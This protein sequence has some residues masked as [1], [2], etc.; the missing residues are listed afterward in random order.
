MAS[1][2]QSVTVSYMAYNT[3]TGAYV[4]GDLANHTIK[5]I[6]DGTETSPT[7]APY[8]ADNNNMPGMYALTLTAAE[9][10]HNVVIIGGKS[11]S[12][13]VIIIP[14]IISFEQLPQAL[15][16]NSFVKASLQDVFNDSTCASNLQRATASIATGS[17]GSGSTTTNIVAGSLFPAMQVVGQYIGRIVIFDKGTTTTALRGQATTIT[18]NDANGNIQVTTLTNAPVLGDTFTIT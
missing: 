17:V 13:N 2:G 4:T 6:K 7:N 11:S 8:E 15:N 14:T 16:T 5:V 1:Y 3:N 10:Q 9:A 18:A 12:A